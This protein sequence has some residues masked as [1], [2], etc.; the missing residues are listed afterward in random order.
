MIIFV[1]YVYR[2]LIFHGCFWEEWTIKRR[3]SLKVF[4][5]FYFIEILGFYVQ[6]KSVTFLNKNPQFFE[7]LVLVLLPNVTIDIANIK[8]NLFELA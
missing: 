3:I 6:Y 2:W 5:E 7:K 1:G 4:Y 8:I